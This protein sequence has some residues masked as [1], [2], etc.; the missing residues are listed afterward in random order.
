M[1]LLLHCLSCIKDKNAQI[2]ESF[3]ALSYNTWNCK[4]EFIFVN[5]AMMSL[6]DVKTEWK[7]REIILSTQE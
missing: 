2:G 1:Q 3:L 6:H 5:K 4:S 7:G